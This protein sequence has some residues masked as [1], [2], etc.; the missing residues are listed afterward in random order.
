MVESCKQHIVV[1]NET[2]FNVKQ[3]VFDNLDV[4]DF[5]ILPQKLSVQLRQ[6][7]VNANV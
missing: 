1:R 7:G 2:A 6:D 3:F 4:V 5:G